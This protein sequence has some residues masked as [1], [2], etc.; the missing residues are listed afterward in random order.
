VIER[1][2]HYDAGAFAHYESVAVAVE[3]P[4][5]ALRHV[6][7]ARRKCA[8]CREATK[9]DA[10]NAGFCAAADRDVGLTRTD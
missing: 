7:E 10:I 6:V 5:R 1:L 4:R 3:R 8:R 2:D 9:A